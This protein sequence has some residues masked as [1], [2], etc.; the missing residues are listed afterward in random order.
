MKLFYHTLYFTVTS[1]EL[2]GTQICVMIV[3]RFSAYANLESCHAPVNY[4]NKL[5]ANAS[6]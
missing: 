3:K 4:Q 6:S 1:T 5:S 2:Y